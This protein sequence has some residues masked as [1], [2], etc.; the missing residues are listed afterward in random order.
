MADVNRRTRLDRS[1][2]C[3]V[4]WGRRPDVLR[5]HDRLEELARAA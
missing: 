2:G 5:L 3:E 4:F 1:H